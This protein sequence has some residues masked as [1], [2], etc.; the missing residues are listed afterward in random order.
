MPGNNSDSEDTTVDASADLSIAKTDGVATLTPGTS[1]TYTITLT[2]NG[3]STEPAG[4]VISDPIP[5]GTSG[6]E[7]EADCAIAAGVFTC[8]TSSVL[9]SGGSVSYQL[10]VV[11]PGAY[12]LP[13]LTNTAAITSTPIPDPDASNDSA[14]DVDAISTSADLSIVKTDAVDPVIVGDDITYTL[15]VTNAGPSDAVGVVVTDTLP[16]TMVYV[17][18]TPSQGSCVEL[19]GV[20]TCALGPIAVTAVAT[21]TIV[22]TTTI[23]GV[24]TDVAAVSATTTD[25]VPGNDSDSE[26]TTVALP[27]ADLSVAKTDGVATVDPGTSTTYTITVTNNGPSVEPAGVVVS[28]PVPP[29]TTPSESEADCAIVLGVFTC[30]TSA[31]LGIGASVSY[32][33][34]LALPIS[35]A[36]ATLT[37]TASITSAPLADPDP[38]NDSATDVDAVT[39]AADLSIVKADAPDPVAVGS[40][41]TYTLTITN[42]GPADATGVTVTDTLPGTVTFGTATPSQGS[43]VQAAGV[44]T[45]SLG[46]IF[47]SA[48]A[49]V[50]II[51]TPTAPGTISNVATVTATTL[52]PVPGN[53]SDTEDTLVAAS[54]DLSITKTDGVATVQAGAA[55]TYTITLTNNGPS[56][57]PAG[58]VVTDPIPADTT[59]AENE[60]NCAIVGTT[61]ICTTTDVT[62]GRR[63]GELPADAH[64]RRGLP[65]DHAREHGHDHR[66]A[67]RRHELGERRRERHRCCHSYRGR[68][69]YRQD[70]LDRPRAAGERL[71]VHDHRVQRRS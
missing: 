43:C 39:S 15:T 36:S 19:G 47:V 2:N 14:T 70:R 46:T 34:T 49:I 21:V 26:D 53:N 38:S 9:V 37:N 3:P 71:H 61:L 23:D 5:A 33:L 41:L 4:V 50:T 52:D 30:T 24:F 62:P 51:A 66:V 44:V 1:T 12:A 27:S 59:A 31:P 17:S 18:S 22:V 10:T 57:A 25:P 45:C 54:A 68:A 56:D 28:D 42:N 11:V 8:T 20:V 60:A 7:S 48:S 6:S 29:G 67:H 58:V 63:V 69:L 40:V 32:Q 65:V 16:G 55:T 13:T 35:Y 64:T